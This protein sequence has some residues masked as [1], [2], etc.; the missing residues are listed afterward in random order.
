MLDAKDVADFFLSPIME[1]E[2][3]RITNLKLQKLLYYAQGYSLALLDR[4]L[5][6]DKIENWEHGPVV[7][8]IYQMYRQHG[9]NP[10]PLSVIELDRYKEEELYI[11]SRVRTEKGKYTAWALRDQTHQETPWLTTRRGDEITPNIMKKY[12]L[13]VMSNSNFNFDLERMK[14]S[15]NDRFVAVPQDASKEDLIKW[16]N[17]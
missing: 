14:K 16:I 5:F 9:A 12:F 2:G 10:L 6:N 3:E 17:Q 4:A 15:V 1:E 7:P 13:T 11:L 8:S